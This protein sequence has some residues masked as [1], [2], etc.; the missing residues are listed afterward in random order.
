MKYGGRGEKEY[1]RKIE[2][3]EVSNSLVLAPPTGSRC[4]TTDCRVLCMRLVV[5]TKQ[6]PLCLGPTLAP[7]RGVYEVPTHATVRQLKK[8]IQRSHGTT[9]RTFFDML[10][11]LFGSRDERL[12]RFVTSAHSVAQHFTDAWMGLQMMAGSGLRSGR[13]VG[14]MRQLRVPVRVGCWRGPRPVLV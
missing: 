5:E 8:E 12:T 1:G 4:S 7:H 10:Q 6:R 14:W 9:N 11:P 2:Q 3:L 13:P